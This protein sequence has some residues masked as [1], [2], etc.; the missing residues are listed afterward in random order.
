MGFGGLRGS[1]LHTLASATLWPP[2]TVLSIKMLNPIPGLIFAATVALTYW[3]FP[4][5]FTDPIT[6]LPLAAGVIVGGILATAIKVAAQWEKALLFRLG[7]FRAVKGPGLFT[8]L[9]FFD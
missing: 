8:I 9:P 5:N 3:Q 6:F 2:R 1:R 7:T 4:P